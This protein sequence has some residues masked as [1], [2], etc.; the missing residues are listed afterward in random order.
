MTFTEAE[1]KLVRRIRKLQQGWKWARWAVLLM[2]VVMIGLSLWFFS[3]LWQE[4][5]QEG[6]LLRLIVVVAPACSLFL[7]AGAVCVGYALSSWRGRLT[8]KLLLRLI[9]ESNN[10]SDPVLKK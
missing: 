2:G 7:L 9:E 1:L 10:A 5:K 3:A 4:L 6:L 8:T